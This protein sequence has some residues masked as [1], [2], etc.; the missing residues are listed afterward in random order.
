VKRDGRPDLGGLIH[1]LRHSF[2]L[3]LH[4]L[5]SALALCGRGD[6][7]ADEEVAVLNIQQ[8]RLDLQTSGLKTCSQPPRTFNQRHGMAWHGMAQTQLYIIHTRHDTMNKYT[9]PLT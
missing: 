2:E 8:Q 1:Q 7:L 5:Q 9:S 4:R 6:E 3:L